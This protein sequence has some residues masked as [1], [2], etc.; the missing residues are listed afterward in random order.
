MDGRIRPVRETKQGYLF[1]EGE[2]GRR[3]R[4]EGVAKVEDSNDAAQEWK[5]QARG[6]VISRARREGQFNAD[7]LRAVIG[8]P[9]NHHNAMG[10]VFLWARRQGF[11]TRVGYRSMRRA[12]AHARPTFVY[13]GCLRSDT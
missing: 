13:E 2:E 9:P 8:P 3:L 4:D 7:D 5:E 11:I 12:K 6:W 10:A 1:D